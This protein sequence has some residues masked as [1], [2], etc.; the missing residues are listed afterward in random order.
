[1][2]QRD[3]ED[4]GVKETEAV[5]L[6]CE[7]PLACRTSVFISECSPSPVHLHG[8]RHSSLSNRQA[9]RIQHKK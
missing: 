6:G 5:A 9:D 2:V 8:N 7:T 1:M 3:L 4:D